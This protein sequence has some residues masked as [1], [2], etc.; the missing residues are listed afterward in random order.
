MVHAN[1]VAC[2]PDGSR[3]LGATTDYIFLFDVNQPGR[4]YERIQSRKYFRKGILSAITVNPGRYS[5]FAVGSYNN[6]IGMIITYVLSIL[7]IP[8]TEFDCYF[9]YL[10]RK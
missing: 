5:M 1:C 9:R 8:F 7:K 10:R 3:I 4:T 2:F 6:R